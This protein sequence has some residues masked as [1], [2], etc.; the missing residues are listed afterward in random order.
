MSLSMQPGL[1]ISG[2]KNGLIKVWDINTTI[3]QKGHEGC[4]KIFKN[5]G[6]NN[7]ADFVVIENINA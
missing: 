2:D 1:I 6:F 7:I 4:V 5:T 3:S